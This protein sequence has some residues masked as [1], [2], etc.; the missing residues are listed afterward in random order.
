MCKR[1]ESVFNVASGG[2]T[3]AIVAICNPYE[4][5]QPLKGFWHEVFT[6]CK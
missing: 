3:V 2:V 4:H 6:V 5:T 1:N